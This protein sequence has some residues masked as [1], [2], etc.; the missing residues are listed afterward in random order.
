MQNNEISTQ[1]LNEIAKAYAEAT[2]SVTS[3]R[4]GMF[5]A[6]EKSLYCA[7][8]VEKCKQLRKQD[9]AGF[10]APVMSGQEVKR[11]LSLHDA[12]R[13]R[14]AMHDKRQLQLTGILE[15]ANIA[16]IEKTTHL[17]PSV[18]SSS[19]KFIGNFTK[20]IRRRPAEDMDT[21]EKEQVKE[22]LKPVIEFYNS[23]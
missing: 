18:I 17:P 21:S 8:L 5:Q 15:A 6:I 4:G 2:E 23:L 7:S 1:M 13:K 22:V 19:R 11:L 14:P 20:A 16:T 9:L 10:L 3:A 12:S